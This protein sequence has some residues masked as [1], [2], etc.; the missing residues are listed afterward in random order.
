MISQK[1][2]IQL[3]SLVPV[4]KGNCFPISSEASQDQLICLYM[5]MIWDVDMTVLWDVEL[6]VH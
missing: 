6:C 2:P 1:Y 4:T 3:D 5:M